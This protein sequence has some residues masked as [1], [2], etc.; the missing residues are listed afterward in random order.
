M[1]Q[2]PEWGW[3]GCEAS[4]DKG[5]RQTSQAD[6][7][8]QRPTVEE[9]KQPVRS[10][11]P[12]SLGEQ[13]IVVTPSLPQTEHGSV[14]FLFPSSLRTLTQVEPGSGDFVW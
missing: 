3:T 13:D 2:W 11:R 4:S 5:L 1:P 6:T 14:S 7:L 12:E 8:S 9:A 10:R